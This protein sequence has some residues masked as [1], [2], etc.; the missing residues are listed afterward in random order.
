V[1]KTLQNKGFTLLEV[2]VAIAIL[3]LGLTAILSAQAGAFSASSHARN[4]GVAL[5][6]ARC[7]MTEVEEK[8]AVE[9][10]QE[11]DSNESGICCEGDD[12][13]GVR[14]NWRVEKPVLPEAKLGDLNLNAGLGSGVGDPGG[15][16]GALLAGG[17]PAVG[18][19][20]NVGDVAKSFAGAASGG[21]DVAG[22]AAGGVSGIASMV[23]GLVYP[24]LK[25]IFEAS[26]RRITA[27]VVWTEGRKD[28]SVELVQWVVSPQKA[29]VMPD[30][31]INA[32]NPG[33]VP[34]AGTPAQQTPPSGG[35]PR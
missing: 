31:L 35:K 3:G 29:G 28:Y 6:L 24:S 14:C 33:G 13:P 1:K 4:L 2:M 21:V 20:A 9:G 17:A 30:E 27:T 18:S 19:N 25:L 7:K 12:T 16:L 26:T 10:F 11:L 15:G 23:M 22:V 5:G 34:S 8:L 32:L